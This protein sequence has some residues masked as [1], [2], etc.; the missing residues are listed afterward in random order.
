MSANI[1]AS[2]NGTQAI[3]GV[4]G[5]DQMTVSNAGVVT[6]NSFVGNVTGG[7]LSGNASSATVLATGST[8][9][10]TL[11]NRFAD[12]AN[13]RDFGAV[14]D[15]ITDDSNA[16]N[17]AIAASR[18][19]IV[20][21]G[22]YRI[23]NVNLPNGKTIIAYGAYFRD[24]PG[25]A[26]MFKLTD[27]GS[28]LV[29]AYISNASNCSQA[30][31]VIGGSQACELESIRIFAAT[32]AIDLVGTGTGDDACR[33][34]QLSN[35]YIS[36]FSDKGIK[37]GANTIDISIVD[38]FIVAGGIVSPAD[39]TKRIP[40]PNSFGVHIDTQSPAPSVSGTGGHTLQNVVV[41]TTET[42]IYVNQTNFVKCTNCGFDSI[43][44]SGA[45]I[46]GDSNT[47][48]F[49]GTIFGSCGRGIFLED[50][51]SRFFASSLRTIFNG[52]IPPWGGPD[53]Y[54]S[55]GLSAI[56]YD[57]YV[58]DTAQGV[59]DSA[60]WVSEKLLGGI[61]DK[62]IFIGTTADFEFTGG[63]FLPLNSSTTVATGSTTFLGINGQS[64][65][66]SS[67][68]IL[69]PFN[70]L[71]VG[72]QFDCVNTPTAGET[73]TYTLRDNGVD[74]A[75]TAQTIGTSQTSVL[76]GN[77]VTLQKGDVVTVKLVTSAGA[78]VTTHRGYIHLINNLK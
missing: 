61:P 60:S 25:A 56:G 76:T 33:R 66:E 28:R 55:S 47:I 63:I 26:Y 67:Q 37:I 1:K 38:T 41:L 12:V 35:I 27:Y 77:F 43:S 50:T 5:I 24:L 8:T 17:L 32:T 65:L 74:T 39:P 78:S 46:V 9:T 58:R 42:G 62:Y 15:N 57:V 52:D 18:T 29:G 48:E 64:A 2:V 30:A 19:I 11:A 75:M 10:R 49:I 69:I 16:F 23:K 36:D 31:I 13:V 73:F 53:F 21:S 6:A 51:V 7:T 34:A 70:C 68:Q 59:I 40:T 3:I 72:L 22:V 71:A 45:H 44:G 4:G 54:T 20:P 14:G